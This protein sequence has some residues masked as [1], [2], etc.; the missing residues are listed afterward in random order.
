MITG[1]HH[2]AI[3]C[4]EKQPALDFYCGTLGFQVVLEY[5]RPERADEILMLEGYGFTIELFVEAGRPARPTEPEAYGLRHLALHVDDVRKTVAKIIAA[6]YEAEPL[7]QNPFY[8]KLL[9]FVKD[10]DGLPIELHE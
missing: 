8:G 9:T 7:R 5:A 4:S 6:G 2:V 3:L 10:P 1:L